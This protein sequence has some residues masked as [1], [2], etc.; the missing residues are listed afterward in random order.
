[1]S[2]TYL[3][4]ANALIALTLTDHEH[5][6]RATS[7]AAGVDRIAV[8]PVVEGSLVRF[9]VR[10]G[11]PPSAATG[12]LDALHASERCEFWPAELS[13]RDADLAHVVGHRQVTDAY[14]AALAR[15]RH[16]VLATFD[17]A[18]ARALPQD[19]VLIL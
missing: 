4:D 5:H 7:W 3:L 14:L 19:V 1:M 15:H 9:L 11:A 2:G 6:E 12:L 13:Y 10:L 18:L 8:C 17:G 16:G